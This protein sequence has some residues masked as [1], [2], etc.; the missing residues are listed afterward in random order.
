VSLKV[1]TLLVK[2]LTFDPSNARKHSDAN[3]AAI[4][5]SLK[6]FGQRKPIVITEDNVIVAGNGTVEAARL[7]GLTDVD[8]VR[9]PKDWSADQ[10]KAFALADNR[11]AELAEWNEEILASQ[12]IELQQANFVIEALGF[13]ATVTPSFEPIISSERLDM[14]TPKFC[15]NCGHDITNA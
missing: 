8:V 9:V 7:L 2:N 5:E 14:K 6:Q 13:Q 12:L 11:T 3:L 10:V 15:A 1:E 4:A